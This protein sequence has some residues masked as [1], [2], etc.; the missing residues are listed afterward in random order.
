MKCRC[1]VVSAFLA[2]LLL[3]PSVLPGQKRGSKATHSQEGGDR[4]KKWLNQDVAYI[5]SPE[6]KS[7]FQKLSTDEEKEQFIE[8]FWQRRNPDPR[9]SGNEFKEEHYR[10]LTYANEHFTS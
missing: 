7:I 5:I 8:Q 9:S 3:H 4:F 6:E 2:A 1:I 10:R